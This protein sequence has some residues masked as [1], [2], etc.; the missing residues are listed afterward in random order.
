MKKMLIK[1]T[2]CDV[3]ICEYYPEKI[4]YYT[5]LDGHCF[6][7]LSYLLKKLKIRDRKVWVKHAS[8][9][10]EVLRYDGKM[11][12][13]LIRNSCIVNLKHSGYLVEVI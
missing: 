13:I 12:Y 8:S 3:A 9:D 1:R 5:Q 6:I 2:V 11:W 7:Y 10:D 4:L